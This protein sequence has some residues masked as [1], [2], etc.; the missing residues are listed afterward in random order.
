MDLKRSINIS[1][2]IAGINQQQLADK[3]GVA[4]SSIS[5]MVQRGTCHT[6]TITKMAEVFNI[7]SSEF[8]ARG[9]E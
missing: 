5:A 4:P 6:D 3:M 2:A 1:L 7:R 8:I 9:E